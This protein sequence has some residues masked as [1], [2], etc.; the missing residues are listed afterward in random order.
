VKYG[1]AMKRLAEG[2]P[3]ARAKWQRFNAP[4]LKLCGER[5]KVCRVFAALD[6][7]D[8]VPFVAELED[9]QADDWLP[10]NINTPPRNRTVTS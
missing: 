4:H 3:V 1:M 5:Q 9:L 7:L 8:P 6:Y 2:Q 10:V